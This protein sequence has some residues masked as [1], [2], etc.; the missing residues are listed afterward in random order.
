MVIWSHSE[1]LKTLW[2]KWEEAIL[3]QLGEHSL[4]VKAILFPNNPEATMKGGGKRVLKITP[5]YS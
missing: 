4:C 5:R 2:L 1:T 3:W